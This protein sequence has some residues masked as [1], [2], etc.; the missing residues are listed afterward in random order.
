MLKIWTHT[1]GA[2]GETRHSHPR[3]VPVHGLAR[4]RG[5]DE[6][7][8]DCRSCRVGGDDMNIGLVD[9]DGHNYPN[10][11]LMKLSAW[12]KNCG[13]SVEFANMFGQYDVL[14]AS[15]VF[16]WSADDEYCYATRDTKRGGTG[17]N[18]NTLPD[19]IEHACPDYEL[20]HCTSAYGFLT[21][22]CPNK[23]SWCF[24]PDKEGDIRPHAEIDEFLDG[25]KSAVLMDNNVLASDHGIKQIEQIAR[26][27]IRV[28]FNQGLDARLIDAPI[29]KLLSRVKWLAPLRMACDSLAMLPRVKSAVKL[30]RAA[31]VTPQRYFCY[32]L[33]TDIDSAL[34]RVESLRAIN[35]DPFAQAF[36]DKKGT[37]PTREQKDFC[38]WVN[39]KAI[40]KS[41]MWEQYV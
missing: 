12:H 2:Y 15:K 7:L 36:R 27:G 5:V 30:L 34:V 17:Y 22:G 35:V 37:P 16:S 4:T 28:D 19:E 13:H 21:R 40:F 26:R 20:Y 25:M 14:Y 1:I 39:H 9:V 23:C 18:F 8:R 33:V 41:I 11:A 10:L 29:A 38:R 24:V 6:V 31:G 32:V 3:A